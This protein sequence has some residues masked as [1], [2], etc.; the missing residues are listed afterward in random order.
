MVGQAGKFEIWPFLR[1][2]RY[3]KLFCL[4][5]CR[6]LNPGYLSHLQSSISGGFLPFAGFRGTSS[7][8]SLVL[9]SPLTAFVLRISVRLPSG[10]PISVVWF[11]RCSPTPRQRGSPWSLVPPVSNRRLFPRTD[12]RLSYVPW[13]PLLPMIWS[14]T[15]T[16]G[17]RLTLAAITGHPRCREVRGPIRNTC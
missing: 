2:L 1:Q 9:W 5:M 12:V 11:L 4:D 10:P 3:P 6:A 14:W 15:P 8:A 13:E 17:S 16:V 7:P